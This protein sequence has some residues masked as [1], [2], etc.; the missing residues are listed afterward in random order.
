MVWSFVYLALRRIL[1]LMVLCW[2]S[3]RRQQAAGI[4]ACDFPD[5][6]HRVPAA[7]VRAV[8]S[9]SCRPGA[10]SWLASPPTHRRVGRP[11]SPQPPRH[12]DDA[13]AVR[14]LIRDRDTKFTAAFDAVFGSEGIR[15]VRTPIRAPRANALAE[16]WVATLRRELLDRMLINGRRQLKAALSEYLMHYNTHHPH[17]SLDQASPLRSVPSPSP[18]A[19]V[20]VLRQDRLGGLIHEY[21]HVA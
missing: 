18:A 5:R 15:V 13:T 2:R 6:G 20:G 9:F 10:S 16:R 3:F 12:H 21:A 1:E 4:L 17:R 14:F 7:A 8:S 11:A 19:T